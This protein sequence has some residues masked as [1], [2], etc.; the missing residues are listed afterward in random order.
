LTAT[1]IVPADGDRQRRRWGPRPIK[2][3]REFESEFPCHYIRNLVVRRQ[4]RLQIFHSQQFAV[5][6][7]RILRWKGIVGSHV[8][9]FVKHSKRMFELAV[10]VEVWVWDPLKSYKKQEILAFVIEFCK[11]LGCTQLQPQ[12]QKLNQTHPNAFRMKVK[13]PSSINIF[14]II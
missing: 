11:W 9:S 13:V 1:A 12:P 4:H 6:F 3:N 7:I 2:R 14:I 5:H 10:E 8:I